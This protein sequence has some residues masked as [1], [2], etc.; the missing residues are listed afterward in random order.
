[1]KRMFQLIFGL[2]AKAAIEHCKRKENL[3]HHLKNVGNFEKNS[4]FSSELRSSKELV[5][6]LNIENSDH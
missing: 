3:S 5:E 2:D 6:L 1:M 4:N